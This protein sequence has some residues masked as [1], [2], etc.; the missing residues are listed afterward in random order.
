MR[1]STMD[2]RRRHSPRSIASTVALI[3]CCLPCICVV[4]VTMIFRK[5]AKR[6]T[7]KRRQK[8][9]AIHVQRQHATEIV[10]TTPVLLPPRL[11][12]HLTIGRELKLA[13]EEV[14]VNGKQ[15][16]CA[17]VID[18]DEALEVTPLE[19]MRGR[20]DDQ[21]QSRL[22]QLPLEIRRQIW[23]ETLCGYIFHM[24]FMESYRCMSHQR[25][26]FR[27]PDDVPAGISQ[28]R[29]EGPCSCRSY[30]KSKGIPDKWGHIDILALLQ[31]CR[32]VYS[33]GIEL[34]Y[35][36]NTFEFT[37]LKDVMRLSLTI[38]PE[39]MILIQDVNWKHQVTSR[40][41]ALSMMTGLPLAGPNR[42]S[43]SIMSLAITPWI[44]C[45]APD[46]CAC[47]VCWPQAVGIPG[48]VPPAPRSQ[49]L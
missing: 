40:D 46:A 47:L 30:V 11:E 5:V 35:T 31:T 32:R 34:L 16:V 45:R 14:M 29:Q 48:Y 36:H 41:H 17:D 49:R 33:E 12:K 18:Q 8:A 10:R 25:C 23:E 22:F 21:M 6:H 39:R 1:L 13:D 4:G 44:E 38:L 28:Y 26:I 19:Q 37:C 2:A 3:G 24:Y 9:R 7:R 15:D 27:D 20:T 42:P 43:D